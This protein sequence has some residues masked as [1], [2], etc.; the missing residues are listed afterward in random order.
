MA[1]RSKELINV[2]YYL[3]RFG[4]KNPPTLL[5]VVKWK[6]AYKLFYNNLNEGR[7]LSEFE[8]S[9]KN[10]RY[11]FDGY[12]S[13]TKREGWKDDDGSTAKL[14]GFS[15][16]TYDEFEGLSEIEAFTKIKSFI[17]PYIEKV[18]NKSSHFFKLDLRK[19]I[20]SN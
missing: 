7:S 12:F 13:E 17:S 11:A 8:H 9:L 10:S 18:Y 6:E 2:G 20:R 5:E 19:V 1:E 14:S 3:S 16:E 4:K 15:L